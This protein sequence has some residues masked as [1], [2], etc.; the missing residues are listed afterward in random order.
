MP[1]SFWND[2]TRS[3]DD[4]RARGLFAE[5]KPDIDA[6]LRAYLRKNGSYRSN[7]PLRNAYLG[8]GRWSGSDDVARSISRQRRPSQARCWATSPMLRGFRSTQRA[9]IYQHV[10]DAKQ[11]VVAKSEGLER[12][13]I[14]EDLLSWQLRW[15]RYL[16][17]A[18]RFADARDFLASLSEETR[19][20]RSEQIVPIQL[21]AAAR[22]GT[23]DQTITA[24]RA[25]PQD[26][27]SSEIL[28]DSARQLAQSSDNQP[29]QKVLEFVFAREID[30]GHLEA[31]NF[32][33]LAQARI[34]SG[35]VPGAVE[36]LRRLVLVVG[37]PY[38]N[39]DAAATLFEKSGH[40]QEA[41][42]FL[43]QL[44]KSAPWEP[45]HGLRL[46]KAQ[47]AAAHDAKGPRQVLTNIASSL[48]SPYSTR[49][50]AALALAPARIE[51]GL[52]SAE[53][54][55]LTAEPRSITAATANQPF[56]TDARIKA[57]EGLTDSRAGLELLGATLSDVPGRNDVRIALFRAAA[58]LQQ[59]KLSLAAIST[60]LNL[61]YSPAAASYAA[62]ES[63][64]TEIALDVP[65]GVP[66]AQ[67]PAIAARVGDALA[68]LDRLS[69][70]LRYF[71]SAAKFERF[72]T[73]R[74]ELNAKITVTR[75]Q[76]RR[77]ETN[78][79]RAPILHEALEQQ[80]I[81]RPRLVAQLAQPAR[82]ARPQTEGQKQ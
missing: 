73:R 46:A 42:E 7:L 69:D 25:A 60:F 19:K 1:E 51:S 77:E 56:F 49:V 10:L 53:L 74:K 29:A 47:I 13:N 20:T 37:S 58:N 65:A 35:D 52:G 76:L 24:F 26:A 62:E 39:L 72:A 34:N 82:T 59:D 44:V 5:L 79:T 9:A 11:E 70:A 23:L 80:R 4:L 2:F 36:L 57:A 64:N 31:T 81:V 16:I 32:F 50:E 41:I 66:G 40:N 68:R 78:L 3:C 54:N 33:G 14:Q 8:V 38:E 21:R 28:R 45:G 75:V 18:K 15:A 63:Q 48:A 61:R 55:L 6:L 30:L 22:L 27:P 17:Q 43:D 67:W 71:A 12:E